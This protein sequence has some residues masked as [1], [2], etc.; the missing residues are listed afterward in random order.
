MGRLFTQDSP[1]HV[2]CLGVIIF[3]RIIISST[4]FRSQ[5]YP[6]IG[7]K[8]YTIYFIVCKTYYPSYI[9]CYLPSF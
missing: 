5:K 2:Y 4:P 7:N 8:I 9:L 6:S 1:F 3:L